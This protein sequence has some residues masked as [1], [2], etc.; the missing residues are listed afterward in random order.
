[1]FILY[2][3]LSCM[4]VIQHIRRIKQREN[5]FFEDTFF[6]DIMNTDQREARETYIILVFNV[7]LT[8]SPEA[9]I[10]TPLRPLIVSVCSVLFTFNLIFPL[11]YFPLSL[12]LSS[13]ANHNTYG[14]G[15]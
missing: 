12:G 8:V 7:Y 13:V 15:K 1:M 3:I 9:A 2:A 10:Q 6:R 5:V 14:L 11:C 4:K